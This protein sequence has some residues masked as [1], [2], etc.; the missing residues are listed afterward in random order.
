[1]A[2][3]W[4]AAYLMA[5]HIGRSVDRGT[6]TPA[7]ISMGKL[8]STR[9]ALD[10]AR[11]CR[12]ILGANG[13]TGDYPV[14]RHAANLETVLTYEGTAEIHQLVLGKALTGVDAFG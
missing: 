4:T 12:S 6:A 11:N 10:I 14:M 13:I 2:T 9:T 7:A 3:A 1:M 5:L 8:N